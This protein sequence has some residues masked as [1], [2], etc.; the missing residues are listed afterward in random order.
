MLTPVMLMSEHLEV[1]GAANILSQNGLR[2]VILG[3]QAGFNCWER[4]APE[5]TLKSGRSS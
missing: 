5:D 1:M 4:R 3:I 2:H